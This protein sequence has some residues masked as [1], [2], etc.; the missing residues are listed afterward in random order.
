MSVYIT[1]QESRLAAKWMSD[2]EKSQRR[3]PWQR[4]VMLILALVMLG[5]VTML[6]LT[7]D[8]TLPETRF[9]T[10]FEK[11]TV[12]PTMIKLYIDLRSAHIHRQLFKIVQ[13]FIWA[14]MGMVL[15]LG[16]IMHWNR[17]TRD[18]LLL[19]IIRQEMENQIQ[20]MPDDT[21]RPLDIL[22]VEDNPGDAFLVKE[23]LGEGDMRVNFHIA[24]NG[25]AAI[26]YLNRRGSYTHA[27]RPD[28][29][30]LDI[31]LPGMDGREVIA[32]M[33]RDEKLGDIPVVLLTASE[34]EQDTVEKHGLPAE[35]YLVKPVELTRFIDV[36]KNMEEL[37]WAVRRLKKE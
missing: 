12:S 18:A 37:S 26:D 14:T 19:K 8:G 28:L 31:G 1:S 20:V 23:A 7:I 36:I 6:T 24:E 29:V 32:E 5:G 21:E 30:L 15:L 10:H 9:D 3:W 22:L 34:D 2:L 27:A 35:H 11:D 4:C 25:A 13:I 16:C 33:K 17:H